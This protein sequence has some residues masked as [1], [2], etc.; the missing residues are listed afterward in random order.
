M[1]QIRKGLEANLDVSQYANPDLIYEQME[2][3]RLKLKK[4]KYA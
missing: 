3:I 4:R 2:K 1:L